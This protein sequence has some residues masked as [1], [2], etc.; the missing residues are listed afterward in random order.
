MLE[1]QLLGQFS[2]RR[3]DQ[4][5]EIGSR[6]A[7]SLLA[8]LVLNPNVAHRRERLAGLLWP[9]SSDANA[10]RNLRQTLWQIR[11]A[12]N[13]AASGSTGLE[14]AHPA[15]E[16]I[17]STKS[18]ASASDAATLIAADD[19]TIMFNR[20]ADFS[21]DTAL[22][23]QELDARASADDLI[24]MLNA[25]G[26]ELLPGFYDDWVVLERERAYMQFER[27]MSALLDRLIEAR[28]WDE[29][30]HWGERWIVL[31]GT[32][33]PAYRALMIAYAALGDA[34]KGAE[35][36][37]RCAEA[38]QRELGVEPS[39]Q[40]QALYEHLR[41]GERGRAWDAPQ[42]QLARS[43]KR[44]HNLPVHLT[45]FVGREK[46]MAELKTR[47]NATRLLTLTGAGGT[48]KTRLALQIAGQSLDS[49]PDGVWFIELAALSDPDL[50][51]Q[52]VAAVVDV[53]EQPSQPLTRS[54]IESFH[55]QTCLLYTSP[56]PRD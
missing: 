26:G 34:A 41:A 4:L 19:L 5:I 21:L 12:L 17:D 46:E 35:T 10:R 36:Y 18:D 39:Q 13:L 56:S 6:P 25:Y 47:L 16:H 52:T 1:I 9:D 32:P 53:R 51:P 8:Y 49:F 3:D 40:T 50:I 38:L 7:Q 14:D 2:V 11:R 23:A 37:R 28:R 15:G 42:A 30:L 29:V 27:K 43:P 22:I 31:G 24:G 45:S 54:L 20:P 55:I 44:R 33:E 48:G